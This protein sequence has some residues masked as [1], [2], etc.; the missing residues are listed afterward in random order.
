M[1]SDPDS[2]TGIPATWR[3][4]RPD[5]GA[6]RV[7]RR[8]TRKFLADI[9][10]GHQC[11]QMA[12]LLVSELVTNAVVHARTTARLSVSVAGGTARIEVRDDGPG[13]PELRE[14]HQ[15]HGGYGLRLVDWMSQSW[16]I[17][18]GAGGKAVWFTL[19]L[20]AAIPEARQ[21]SG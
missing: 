8:F 14:P 1:S 16:G 5:P 15:S 3:Q 2:G 4:F 13:W 9:G 10:A 18:G 6:P 19:P 11:Q 21:A 12:E 7:A 17:S 20:S